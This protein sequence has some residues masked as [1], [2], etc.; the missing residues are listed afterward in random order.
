RLLGDIRHS[1]AVAL[2]FI[3]HDI[4]VVEQVCDRILVMYGGRV[5]EDLPTADLR[6]RARHPYTRALIASVPSLDTDRDK[7][8]SVIPGRPYRP[9]ELPAGCAFASRCPLA[10]SLCREQDPPL[11]AV[12]SSRVA[13][14][15]HE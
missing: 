9:D 2:L 13:C 15:H 4:S 11:R 6:E 1:S 10:D 3:S 5:V 12:G 7:P 8:L 14:W